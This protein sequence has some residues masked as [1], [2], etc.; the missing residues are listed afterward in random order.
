MVSMK[1]THRNSNNTV[2]AGMLTKINQRI[3]SKAAM[4]FILT[5]SSNPESLLLEVAKAV[6]IMI[7]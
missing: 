6:A 1:P 7:L 2:S 4:I 3:P 5:P